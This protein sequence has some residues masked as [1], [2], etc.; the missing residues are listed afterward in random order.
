MNTALFITR[1]ITIV[2]GLGLAANL[3]A[4]GQ[5]HYRWT[6]EKGTLQYSDR[7]PKDV[8]SE[9]IEFSTGKRSSSSK[10]SSE[11][12]DTPNTE[13]SEKTAAIPEM[14]VM[15]NKDPKLCNQAKANLKALEKSRI[16]MKDL[17]GSQRFLTE[18]EK[19]EQKDNARKFMKVYC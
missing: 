14:E 11:S 15:P 16:R 3:S 8:E 19:E 7:P 18:E 2:I 5:G 13:G 12:G 10:Q 9:F 17:D 1:L 6:D 4:K